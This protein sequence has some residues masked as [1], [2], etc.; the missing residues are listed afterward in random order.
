MIFHETPVAD[1]RVLE[2][3][4][5][6]DDRGFFARTFDAAVFAE[7]GM[8]PDVVQANMAYNKQRA[9]LRGMHFQHAPHAEAKLIRC[10]RGAVWD[11]IVD[12]RRDSSTFGKWFGVELS[13]DNRL[14]L[15]APPGVAHGYIT[16]AEDCELTYQVSAAYAP[17]AEDGVRWNDP[18]F[19]IEW[20][21]QPELL[22][23]KDANWPLFER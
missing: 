4:R 23:E 1:A 16:L 17:D 9:T 3:E 5:K 14:A 2:L 19:G 12:I 11:A 6:G 13:Q 10:V 8:M 22:S 7:L 18:F 15:Y 20:P 21:I